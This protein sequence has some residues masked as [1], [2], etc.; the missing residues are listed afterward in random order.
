MKKSVVI[1][2]ALIYVASIAVVSFFGLQF[3]IFDEVVPVS[4]IEILNKDLKTQEDGTPYAVVRLDEN[5][6]AQFLIEY[7]VTPENA[8]NTGVTFAYDKTSTVAAVDERGL[9]TF[10]GAGFIKVTIIAA[11]GSNVQAQISIV[12][13]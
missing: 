3:K 10:T 8:T 7:K 2:I 1:L 11:D 9:V 6:R 5:K 12:A 4:T 13:Y